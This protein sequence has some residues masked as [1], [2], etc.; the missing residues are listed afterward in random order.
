MT[1]G[2][3][4]GRLD[5]PH[6][7]N[8]SDRVHLGHLGLP[9]RDHE[10]SL[11]FY[12]TYFGF[13]PATARTY[14]DGTVIVRNADR[15]DLALHPTTGDTAVPAFLHFGF[16]LP[17]PEEVR[18]LRARLEADGVP[19]VESD[20]EPALVSFKC[21]DPDGWRVEVYW[22]PIAAGPRDNM[23][24]FDV[25]PVDAVAALLPDHARAGTALEELTAAGVDITDVEL[26]HG[27]EGIA[28]LDER[29]T[30]HG[31]KAHL[32]RLLQKWTYYEQILL[33]Y[34]IGMREGGTVVVVPST[35]ERSRT[36]AALLLR[37]GAR[38][39]NYF[40]FERV[41]QLSGS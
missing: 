3:R 30:H 34:T 21:L 4:T 1:R 38:S 6:R 25:H 10:R 23:S 13:D 26:L 11:A 9:V 40:G 27:P 29:G 8:K 28:I 15:F 32:V 18:G 16:V 24:G 2:H 31:R 22:E 19:I 35:E 20:D 7:G 33:L 39:I 41:E 36:L 37:H 5:F 12:A 14:A 17:A